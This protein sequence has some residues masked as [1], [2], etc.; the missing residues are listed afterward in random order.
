MSSSFQFRNALNSMKRESWVETEK[1]TTYRL[2]EPWWPEF[3]VS[4]A[5]RL[6]NYNQ[7]DKIKS[8]EGEEF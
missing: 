7:Q 1:L 6:N 8:V 3:S 5:L 4:I 2:T